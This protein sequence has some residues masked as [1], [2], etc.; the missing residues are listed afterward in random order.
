MGMW[1]R[2]VAISR[3]HGRV[4]GVYATTCNLYVLIGTYTAF[5]AFNWNSWSPWSRLDLEAAE[6]LQPNCRKKERQGRRCGDKG[7][8]YK[9]CT[10]CIR[11]MVEWLAT[12]QVTQH[13]VRTYIHFT[14][15]ACTHKHTHTANA[16]SNS[17]N[18]TTVW[19]TDCVWGGMCG[20]V[21][22]RAC[23]C[24]KV[25]RQIDRRVC[26]HCITHLDVSWFFELVKLFLESLSGRLGLLWTQHK[27]TKDLTHC[28]VE[29][30][31]DGG[32]EEGGW[33]WNW[34]EESCEKKGWWWQWGE[35]RWGG[36]VVLRNKCVGHSDHRQVVQHWASN[37]AFYHF[38]VLIEAPHT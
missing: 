6:R 10:T 21:Q 3:E 31:S 34:G 9:F 28:K 14:L 18:S 1:A 17:N 36:L 27:T 8:R 23:V 20:Q 33:W 29:V 24:V 7:C 26:A 15:H 22:T 16:Y 38:T 2:R 4:P 19:Q 32:N 35:E 13:Y 5:A 37:L 30:S 11:G 25:H 12:T